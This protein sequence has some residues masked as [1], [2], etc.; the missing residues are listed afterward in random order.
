MGS[1][2][3]LAPSRRLAIFCTN[4]GQLF[5]ASLGLNELL[6]YSVFYKTSQSLMP[7]H[8]FQ[9]TFISTKQGFQIRQSADYIFQIVG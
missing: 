5:D 3:G 2:N 9:Q 8:F 4:D 6:V 1:D 7:S